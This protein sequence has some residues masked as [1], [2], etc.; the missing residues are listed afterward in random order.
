MKTKK[1]LAI[2]LCALLVLALL[3]PIP[4]TLKDGGTKVFQAVLYRV[5][6]VHRLDHDSERGDQTGTV[7]RIL[8]MK[9]FDSVK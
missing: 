9:V 4:M 7:V 6:L 2:G 8:G 1:K 3:I 5:E